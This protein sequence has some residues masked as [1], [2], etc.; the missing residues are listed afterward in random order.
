MSHAANNLQRSNFASQLRSSMQKQKHTPELRSAF[1]AQP[2]SEAVKLN[3]DTSFL[4]ASMPLSRHQTNV[5]SLENSSTKQKGSRFVH[6]SLR[7]QHPDAVPGVDRSPNYNF[8]KVFDVDP[9]YKSA[10]IAVWV[11]RSGTA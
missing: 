2:T 9:K 1:V 7:D 10:I 8:S 11:S 3:T 5:A 4:V 6:T